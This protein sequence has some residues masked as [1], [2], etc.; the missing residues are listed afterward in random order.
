M[1]RD[2]AN[3]AA[4]LVAGAAEGAPVLLIGPP[5]AVPAAAHG[6]RRVAGE[7]RLAIVA[8]QEVV[9]PAGGE[10]GGLGG[11]AE[12][13]VAQPQDGLELGA[14]L[15]Q[16]V[17]DQLGLVGVAVGV[18]GQA[19][20]QAAGQVP[21]HQGL[22]AQHAAALPPQRPQP[23]GDSFDRLAVQG[24]DREAA[25][26]VGQVG[27]SRLGHGE[28]LPQAGGGVEEE[29]LADG[30]GQAAQLLVG[31]LV[32]DGQRPALPGALE[33]LAAAALVLQEGVGE[34]GDEGG[35]GEFAGVAGAAVPLEDRV[36]RLGVTV[37]L[38]KQQH[39]LGQ[40]QAA[41]DI[42]GEVRRLHQR[43]S[44]G[45]R[46]AATPQ[47]PANPMIPNNLQDQKTFTAVAA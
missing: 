47:L 4:V 11:V 45:R 22:A 32:G 6:G 41:Q 3:V 34:E 12:L 18:G 15:G 39:G 42:G 37:P 9:A 1:Q 14:D 7:R 23:F 24:G 43:R 28:Q 36:E 33:G 21:G 20:G 5:L 2:T 25:Q 13:A 29:V 38:P 10:G 26:G 44:G 35:E 8:D 31:R 46:A 17:G 40:R 16:Q 27:G 30:Q 19:H